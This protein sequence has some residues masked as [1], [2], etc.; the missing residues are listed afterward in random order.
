M[1]PIRFCAYTFGTNARVRR[2]VSSK[3]SKERFK[4]FNLEKPFYVEGEDENLAVQNVGHPVIENISVRFET[5]FP[6]FRKPF[7]N[8]KGEGGFRYLH[9]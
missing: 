2:A 6:F 4:G 3:R 7:K 9:I 1:T 5:N 8:V